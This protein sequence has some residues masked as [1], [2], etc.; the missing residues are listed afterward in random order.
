MDPWNRRE[1]LRTALAAC[2]GVSLDWAALPVAKAA[3]ADPDSFDAVIVGSGLGGLSC[4]AAFARQGFKP[5]VLEQHV[6]AGGYATAFSRPGGFN[7]DVSLHSTTVGERNGVHNLIPGFPEIK[8]VEFV[9]HPHLYRAIFPEHDIRAAQKDLPAYIGTL[10]KSF[11]QEREGIQALFDDITGLA[12]EIRKYSAASGKV[13]M[14]R[15][16]VDY[17]HLVA[18]AGKTWGAMVDARIADPKLAAIVSC[19][20]SYYGLPP[21]KLAGIYY[22]YPTISYLQEG[23]YYPRGRS[24]TVSNAFVKFIEE[25]GGKV[26][27]GSRVEAIV[28][29]DG[30]A[31]GVK[32]ADGRE[33]TSRVVVS[34]ANA[35]DTFHKMLAPEQQPKDYLAQ[36]DRYTASLSSF[37]VFLGLT[38]D[39]AGGL[40]MHDTE[41]FYSSGY[42]PEAEYQGALHADLSNPGF[43]VMLY[44]NLFRGYSP[45]GK[46]T[47]SIV[48]LQG[49]DHWQPFEADYRK[50]SKGAYRKE[51]ERMADVL[52]RRA[53][54]VLLPGLSK[55]IEIRE[56]ATPLTNVRYTGNYRGAIYG[57]DQT[58]DNSSR[59]R[60]RHSTPIRNLY[61]SGAWTNPGGGYSAVLGSGLECFGEIMA[62]W[63]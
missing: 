33:Y 57:W 38:K 41:V 45:A 6:K 62:K 7:F 18:C 54:E 30:A 11:P 17:P 28:V 14:A 16:P 58:L 63:G 51:K 43:G 59:T 44:D 56:V 23:G 10:Q 53:E 31:S 37:I 55:A 21:S 42:D 27:L 2:G 35:F 47:L 46:N 22:A 36:L 13:D 50:G 52:I 39:L 32:T 20:W 48:T 29:R 24:Q 3:S 4:A 60:L 15:M 40:G 34:N 1:W 25:H 12:A 8:D 19:L 26:L 9:P 5:L 61:L 49:Y